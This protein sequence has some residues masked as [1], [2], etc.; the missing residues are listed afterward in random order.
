MTVK[1]KVGFSVCIG[2]SFHE[3]FRGRDGIWAWSLLWAP[4]LDM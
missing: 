4:C 3:D 2:Q 1:I